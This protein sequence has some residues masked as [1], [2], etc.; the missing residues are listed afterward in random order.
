MVAICGPELSRR[1]DRF[2][3]AVTAFAVLGAF[4][5]PML[6]LVVLPAACGAAAVAAP[7]GRRSVTAVATWVP[8]SAAVILGVAPI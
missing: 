3:L 7:P 5:V 6:Y 8:V 1:A 4:V 2:A